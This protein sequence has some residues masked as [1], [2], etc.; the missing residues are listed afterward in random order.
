ML[1]YIKKI[2]VV[3]ALLMFLASCG[4]ILKPKQAGKEATQ[5]LDIPIVLLDS[6]G[7]LALVLPGLVPGFYATIGAT[8]GA[9]ISVSS[10]GLDY[11]YNTLFIS[12]IQ[13][14]K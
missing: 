14:S 10:L 2:C 11:Y 13:F 6:T 12:K 5:Q 3:C 8:L 1:K 4:L 7:L 9:A